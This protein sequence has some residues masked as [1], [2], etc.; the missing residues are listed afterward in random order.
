[1]E[2]QEKNVTEY[3]IPA[4]VTTK[5]EFFDG[6]GWHELKIVAI[7][8]LIGTI[9]FFGTGLITK[10]I[11]MKDDNLPIEYTIGDKEDVKRN[12][13][14]LI[15]KKVPFIP[16]PIRLFFIII[17]GIGAFFLVKRDPLNGMSLLSMIKNTKEFKLKQKLYLYIYNSGSDK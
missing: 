10:T 16:T 13:E 12:S 8:L 6:F 9:F 5:F 17:P 4:N 2:Q 3:L 15:E 7:A 14:G 1:M 11:T